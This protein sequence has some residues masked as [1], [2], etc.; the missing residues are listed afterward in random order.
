MVSWQFRVWQ[1]LKFHNFVLE[2]AKKEYEDQRISGH[3][4]EQMKPDE[5]KQNYN[6][7]FVMKSTDSLE[8]VQK[9]TDRQSNKDMNALEIAGQTSDVNPIA[10]NEGGRENSDNKREKEPSPQ[11]Q[12]RDWRLI[13]QA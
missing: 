13:M 11:Y 9:T 3:F 1:F 7:T 4:R 8:K 5:V 6:R 2:I 12:Y 10:L